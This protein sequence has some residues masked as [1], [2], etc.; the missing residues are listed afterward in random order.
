MCLRDLGDQ[1]PPCLER[2][3]ERVKPEGV[4]GASVMA[5]MPNLPPLADCFPE[6]GWN[7]I[8]KITVAQ[9][10]GRFDLIIATRS[11]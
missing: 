3:K 11:R 10:Q 9:P 6:P 5:S 1:A 7:W 2:L 4:I 8:E